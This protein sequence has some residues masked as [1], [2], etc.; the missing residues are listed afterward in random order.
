MIKK[1]IAVDNLQQV[2]GSFIEKNDG[3]LEGSSTFVAE[4]IDS[5][6]NIGDRLSDQGQA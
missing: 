1:G 2:D 6:P 4:D 5:F 3:T